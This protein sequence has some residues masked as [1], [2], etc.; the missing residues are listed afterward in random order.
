M[1]RV[2]VEFLGGPLDGDHCVMDLG[3]DPTATI[4]AHR[5]GEVFSYELERRGDRGQQRI[6]TD[7]PASGGVQ[8]W[9]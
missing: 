2:R 1:E 6:A 4:G 7:E 9:L 3:P 5:K 8:S